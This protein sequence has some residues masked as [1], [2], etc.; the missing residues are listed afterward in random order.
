MH[1]A[2]FDTVLHVR[3]Y[4]T[5]VNIALAQLLGSGGRSSGLPEGRSLRDTELFLH[6]RI[7]LSMQQLSA[8]HE[9]RQ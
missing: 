9:H 2:L 3:G 6:S 5:D 8:H 4:T 1:S 7:G